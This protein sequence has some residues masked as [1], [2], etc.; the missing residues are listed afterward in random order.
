VTYV[1]EPYVHVTDEVLTAL[2]GGVAREAHRFFAGAN[3]FSFEAGAERVVVD[4]VRVIG[5][6]GGAFRSF[7]AG[8]D[9]AIGGDGLLRFLA[10]DDDPTLPA[11]GSTWPDEATEFY[12]GH[13]HTDSDRAL[14]TDRNV[15][16]LTRTLA[17]AF[18]RELTV[19]R[20]QLEMVYRSGFVDT[21]EGSALDLVVA[22]LGLSRKTRDFASGSVRFF[23]DTPA[24]ADI[25]IPAGTKV[26]TA[27]PPAP[28]AAGSGGT[29]AKASAKR[30][31]AFVTTTDR[32]LRRGQLS[33]EA[34][35]RAEEKGAA[36]IVDALSI[37][38]VNEPVLGISGVTNDAQTVFGASGESDDELRR[39]A[40]TVAERAGRA[41]PRAL[42]NALT[43]LS[44]IRENDVKVVEELQLRPGVVQVFLAADPTP[45]LAVQ[46]QQAVLATRAA[47]VRVEHNLESYLP[48]ATGAATS[49]GDL[50]GD[51][52]TEEAPAPDDFRYALRANV[53]VFPENARITGSDKTTMEQA[54]RGAVA[55]YV[56]ASAVGGTLVYNRVAADL[57]D[58]PGILD[59]V[60]DLAPDPGT[61]DT[62]S[63]GRRN[64]VVPQGQRA[65]I[66]PTTGVKVIFAGAPVYFDIQAKVVPK[67]GASL[68]HIREEV[69]PRLVA[70]FA[71]NPNP[72]D[73]VGLMATLG[74]SERYTLDVADLSWTAEYD[75]AGLII[76][77]PGGAAAATA[78]SEGDRPVLRD[79]QVEIRVVPRDVT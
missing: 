60:L 55:A 39:R 14:L 71:S 41:T 16:S 69:R 23:R 57:M 37:S 31:V 4:S 79:V 8:R 54:V 64:I 48:A 68:G 12:V 29:G 1:A 13:Y 43:E 40:K 24:P 3:A 36:G 59:V 2:T 77:E 22:L 42:V 56:G 63:H 53:V 51:G 45:D 7:Q 35:V 21:A 67:G 18:A 5:Q 66:D 75:Q 10:S 73:A 52:A 72:V 30:P 47:G 70:Y 25:F 65:V 27:L 15:G 26:S 49:T 17:E 76:R 33:V 38:V 46:V 74:V 62:P 19:L 11:A 58:I 28:S 6:A 32:T 9:F 44:G 20:S 50:R 61:P 78:L 34:M